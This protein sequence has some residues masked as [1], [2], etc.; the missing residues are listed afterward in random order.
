MYFFLFLYCKISKWNKW[1]SLLFSVLQK[2]LV[3]VVVERFL[4]LLAELGALYYIFVVCR[5]SFL[6]SQ[7]LKGRDRKVGKSSVLAEG[8]RPHAQMRTLGSTVSL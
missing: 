3:S 4:L 2:L 5:N 7:F 6:Y 8:P 1:N